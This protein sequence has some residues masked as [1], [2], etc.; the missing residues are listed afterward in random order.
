[1]SM[2][3]ACTT[4]P[5]TPVQT[6]SAFYG[7]VSGKQW[8]LAVTYLSPGV[9][10]TFTK[11]GQELQSM[12]GAEGDPLDFFLQGIR[13]RLQTPLLKVE[14]IQRDSEKA[15]LKIIAGNCEQDAPKAGC[16][17]SEVAMVFVS[18]KWYVD[19]KLPS[20]GVESAKTDLEVDRAESVDDTRPTGG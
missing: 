17:Q 11:V 18:G 14:E 8:D 3:S 19:P 7:A 10:E 9:R 1:M 5:S 2:V 12:V 15:K 13:A 16:F 4:V 6:Y 20:M